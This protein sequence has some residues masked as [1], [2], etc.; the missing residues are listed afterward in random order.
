MRRDRVY[1]WLVA[2]PRAVDAV[3]AA[4]VFVL[5]YGLVSG[6]DPA[7]LWLSLLLAAPLAW[8][9]TRPVAV[10]AAV[11][12]VAL[13]QWLLSLSDPD[14][15][16][17]PADV[18]V[19]AA[20]YA[21]AAYGPRR[22]SRAALALALLG[23]ALLAVSIGIHERLG[24]VEAGVM[25]LAAA[26]AV[27]LAAWSLGDLRRMRRAYVAQLEE[28]AAR[29]ERER[30]QQAELAT[31]TE[32]AR[33][34]R[35]LHD[36][37]AHSLSVVVAQAD[38]GRYAGAASP[39]AAEGA[40]ATISATGRTA[41]ADMRR[42][43]GVLRDDAAGAT[44]PQPGI[45][46]LARLVDGVRGSGLPVRLVEE[47]IPA[48]VEPGLALAAYRIVQEALTNVLTHAGPATP[49]TVALC[50]GSDALHLTVDDEGG[51]ARRR[52]EGGVGHGQ[53][54]MRERAA[55]YGGS[56]VAGP[57]PSGGYRVQ[58][59]LPYRRERVDERG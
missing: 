17:L 29:L 16:L 35:E 6:G 59:R 48:P 18:A 54:G 19:L 4:A 28:R 9:R 25:V 23:A 15:S 34:A 50:W 47:G 27:S 53:V 39:A 10:V 51:P 36:V 30:E 13:V 8:R 49:T 46:D 2:H 20:L 42:L 26:S 37:V 31:A 24:K 45:E 41:L 14:L 22:A 44:A 21:V 32:R 11:Y 43:L 57:R 38:G 5:G 7:V 55:L 1:A 40:L 3:L 12:G 56:V 52:S 58:A 33:I